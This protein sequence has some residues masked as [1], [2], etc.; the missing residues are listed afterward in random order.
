MFWPR[1]CNGLLAS[2]ALVSSP[3]ATVDG[4]SLP[5]VFEEVSAAAGVMVEHRY[6]AE[7]P[8]QLHLAAGGAAGGDLD[9]DGWPDLY[10]IGGD[11]GR[12]HLFRNL[13]DGTFVEV[14]EAAGVDLTGMLAC[15][16]ALAD[17]DGDG[18]LDF[19]VG[20]IPTDLLR[21]DPATPAPALFVNTGAMTFSEVGRPAG[22]FP[23]GPYISASFG[24]FDGD[25]DLDL[26]TSHWA[27]PMPFIDIDHLWRNDGSGAFLP[28]TDS[29]GLVIAREVVDASWAF[30]WSFTANF[31]DIDSD[32]WPDLLLASDF[33]LSQ[34][35]RNLG[36]GRFT[37]ISTD[38]LTDEN[39][40]GAAVAD[41]DNDG[42]L[43]WFVTSIFD[44]EGS[45][46]G[47]DGT[48]GNRLYRND[49]S[50]TFEDVTDAAGVR[51][52]AWGWG[53]CAADFN[54]DGWIDIFHVNGW[55][56]PF[57]QRFSGLPA[58]LF[59]NRGD[60]TFAEQAVQAGIDDRGEG[61]GVVC[62]DY[63]RDGD[64][65]VFVANQSGPVRLY[66]NQ[67]DGAGNFLQVKLV[68]RPPNTEGI[69]AHIW[70]RTDGLEQ[71]RELRAGS[72]YVSQDPAVAH[73]GLSAAERIDEL[74]VRWPGG[75]Q[76]VIRN[77]AANR[78]LVV[79][80]ADGDA[81]CD[82]V[83]AAADL[84]ALTR[85]IGTGPSPAPCPGGDVNYDGAV[86]ARDLLFTVAQLFA[87]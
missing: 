25:G 67:L 17:I 2:L 3:V 15:G 71:L 81:N 43:D 58:V 10:V 35:F 82:G 22:M 52:G 63:D 72:N 86:D 60:G 47:R 23:W 8:D 42:D 74:E 46:G 29:A 9:G 77:L 65:D 37:D 39:G 14:A 83:T 36:N 20:M 6:R 48:T 11:A 84:A 19:F 49:G 73:F 55:G 7:L 56:F 28:A 70:L 16:P 53:A 68:G 21:I 51:D 61:R 12:Q 38:V 34:V 4:Q 44:A 57:S 18:D 27:M 45:P 87:H 62:F 1:F 76:T 80:Q 79:F 54:N 24:D 31:S 59:M 30:S 66:K 32:G 64:I 41:F 5:V 50:G 33:G 69:G 78:H 75:D 13:G 85:S 26:F 40:M